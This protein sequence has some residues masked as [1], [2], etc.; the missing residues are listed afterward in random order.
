[1]SMPFAFFLGQTEMLIILVIAVLLF[2]TRIPSVMR[3]M[4]QGITEFKKGMK[5][6]DDDTTG[7]SQK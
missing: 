2:G 5:D 3:S 7:D 6:T 1:M 4:G